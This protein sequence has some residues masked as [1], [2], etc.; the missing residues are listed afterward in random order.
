MTI[1]STFTGDHPRSSPR[2]KP[3][4][5]AK[6]AIWVDRVGLALESARRGGR[7]RYPGC[8]VAS[9]TFAEAVRLDGALR[10]GIVRR[11]RGGDI[12]DVWVPSNLQA[13]CGG[14]NLEKGCK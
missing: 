3:N 8:C 7:A 10:G 4:L 11:H 2:G 13:L 9:F 6:A 14:C 12:D 1:T 5:S